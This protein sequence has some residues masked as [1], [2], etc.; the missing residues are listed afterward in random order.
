MRVEE[1]RHTTGLFPLDTWLRL[2]REA[3]FSVEQKSFP[4]YEGGYGGRL[5]IGRLK[6]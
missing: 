6:A 3:G 2:M 4:V 5:L 1:D